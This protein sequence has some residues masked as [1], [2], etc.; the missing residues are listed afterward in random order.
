MKLELVSI[1]IPA[2]NVENYTDECLDSAFSQTYPEV[3]IIVVD[4]NSSD[5]TLARLNAYKKKEPS[6]I[7]LSEKKQGAPAARNKGLSVAKGNWIQFLDADDLLKPDKIQHQVKLFRENTNASFIA[8]ACEVLAI[9]KNTRVKKINDFQ[10][11]WI[12]LTNGNLG[13]TCS[14]FFRRDLLQEISGWNEIL[15]SS[16]EPEL[17]FR[18]MKLNDKVIVDNIPLTTIRMRE[19][20]SG[21]ISNDSIDNLERFIRLRFEIIKYLQ[22]NRNEFYKNNIQSLWER[23]GKLILRNK[24][25]FSAKVSKEFVFNIPKDFKDDTKYLLLKKKIH[26]YILKFRR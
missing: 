2:Y 11:S 26:R 18:L 12:H 15:K 4:N 17:M 19:P 5:N 9:D 10:S 20:N 3:E 8:G 1:I 21:R 7:V 14:N 16:Q 6:L 25:R 23:V 24:K 22:E 13:N